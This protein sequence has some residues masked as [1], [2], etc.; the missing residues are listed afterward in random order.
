[1]STLDYLRRHYGVPAR[2]HGRVG[3][4]GRMGTIVGAGP[5]PHLMIRL[6]GEKHARPYHPTWELIYWDDGEIVMDTRVQKL[7]A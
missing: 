6:D 4:Q 7:T 3:F 2:P 1:M 5:G